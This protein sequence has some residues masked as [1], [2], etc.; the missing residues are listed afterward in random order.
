[1]WAQFHGNE[2]KNEPIYKIFYSATGNG[3]LKKSITFVS[4]L[5][6]SEN[7]LTI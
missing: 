2:I 4:A 5:N 1:M 7:E 3:G 6:Y